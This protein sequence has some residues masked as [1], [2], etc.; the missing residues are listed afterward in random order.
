[1]D[2][3]RGND[4]RA[5]D[6]GRQIHAV[7]GRKKLKIPPTSFGSPDWISEVREV[8]HPISPNRPL[9]VRHAHIH[10]GGPIPQPSV[11]FP[12]QHPYCEF[13]FQFQGRGT[14]FIGTEQIEKR[15]GDLMLIGPGTP[16]NALYLEYPQRSAT[17]HFLPMLL[18][19]MG[20]EG[21]G[22]LVL[23]R[24]TAAQ[25]I[26]ERVLR[27][28]RAMRE[29][30]AEH[31]EQMVSEFETPQPGAE[32][33][34]R[35]LLMEALVAFMRWEVATGKA[36]DRK[37]VAFHWEQVEKALRF[38]HEN[39]AEP[40]YVEQ[41]ARATGLSASRLQAMFREALGMSC[42]QYLR[43]YRISHAKAMLCAPEARVTEVSL[44]VGFETLSHFNTSF[45]ALIGMSP[46]AYIRSQDGKRS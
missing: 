13:N 44:A 25:K 34:L 18:F 28:P 16:H 38:I 30:L 17:I 21:D 5:S 9:W 22:A 14:Q 26:G 41:I 8:R 10:S 2:L 39:Y 35:A 46:T 7:S 12:E 43:T 20:P 31:F 3:L 42:V 32:L 40:L 27:L 15:P 4:I 6:Q 37:Q 45:R 29:E 19:E 1:L 23:A 33:R 11:P 24:F 36:A